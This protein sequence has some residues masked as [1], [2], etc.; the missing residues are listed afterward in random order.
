MFCAYKN[1]DGTCGYYFEGVCTPEREREC[2]F[3]AMANDQKQ[4][5]NIRWLTHFYEEEYWS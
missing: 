5:E 2:N 4:A 1:D 3:K